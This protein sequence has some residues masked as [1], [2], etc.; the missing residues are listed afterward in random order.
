MD[1]QTVFLDPA[2]VWLAA[3][4]T[5]LDLRIEDETVLVEVQEQDLAGFQPSFGPDLFRGDVQHP[6]LAGQDE[7]AVFT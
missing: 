4:E 1:R 3:G 6:G 2:A 5:G 7:Q